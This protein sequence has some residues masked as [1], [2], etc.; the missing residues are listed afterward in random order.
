MGQDV[1][2]RMKVRPTEIQKHLWKLQRK[3]RPQ[4]IWTFTVQKA[5]GGGDIASSMAEL[6]SSMSFVPRLDS[7]F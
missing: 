7:Q 5:R 6:L 3:R 1:R 4:K 2:M